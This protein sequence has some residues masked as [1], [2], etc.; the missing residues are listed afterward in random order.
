MRGWRRTCVGECECVLKHYIIS[1]PIALH[2]HRPLLRG[3]RIAGCSLFFPRQIL[4]RPW[5]VL[6]MHGVRV[7]GLLRSA[8]QAPE[9]AVDMQMRQVRFINTTNVLRAAPKSAGMW[10]GCL[11]LPLSS[12]MNI[13]TQ[14][15]SSE[16]K[17]RHTPRSVG[18]ASHRGS[19]PRWRGCM[20]R[21]NQLW[22][23]V[24]G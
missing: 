9:G 3:S 12:C 13:L 10:W 20:Y 18:R 23:C 7:T 8:L 1:L 19:S 22:R 4:I 11:F 6:R 2:N 24:Q 15:P 16:E 5:F 21:M 14:F 17:S